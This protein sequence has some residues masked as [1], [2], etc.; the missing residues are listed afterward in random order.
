[1]SFLYLSFA[2]F[3]LFF[4][5]NVKSKIFNNNDSKHRTSRRNKFQ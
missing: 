5:Y 2:R 3:L 1:M 4:R